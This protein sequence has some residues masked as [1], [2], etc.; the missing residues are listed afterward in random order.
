MDTS[1]STHFP[2]HHLA[3]GARDVERVAG[4]YTNAVGLPELTRHT[5]ESGA[6]RSVWLQMDGAIL[7]IERTTRSREAVTGVDAGL[8]LLAFRVDA[9]G[10]ADVETRLLALGHPAESRTEHTTYFRDPEG[11]RFAVSHYPIED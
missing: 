3:L 5:D 4:F 8:F 11:N 10:R 9:K 7:M 2:L 6:L 1:P